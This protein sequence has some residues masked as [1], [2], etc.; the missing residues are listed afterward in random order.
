MFAIAIPWD[1][2]IFQISVF[3]FNWHSAFAIIG[4]L[5]G[6]GIAQ[7][8]GRRT[9]IPEDDVM[10]LA[11]CG[12]GGG[13]M[14]ARLLYVVDNL[15]LFTDNWGRIFAFHEGGITVWGAPLGGALGVSLSAWWMKH[16]VRTAVDIGSPGLIL[17]MAIGRIGDLV[18]GEHHALPSN[19]P[20]AVYYTHENTLGQA[21]PIHPATTYE[22]FGDLVIFALAMWLVTRY[23]GRLYVFW[24]VL[25]GYSAMRFGLQFLRIDQPVH[26]LGLQ[27]SQII[28]L[29]V[30]IA[31]GLWITNGLRTN[32]W[33]QKQNA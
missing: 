24:T 25:A 31:F 22:L 29:I 16:P 17:G 20:W 26:V 30:L 27:Q 19:L 23:I 33:H 13:I 3:R 14:M 4:L 11:L 9:T 10:T 6:V 28:G 21:T 12:L 7:R 5:V 2:E 8:L 32:L 1:P 15:D 18:N